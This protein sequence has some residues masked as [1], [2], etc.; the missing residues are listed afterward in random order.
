MEIK[1]KTYQEVEHHFNALSEAGYDVIK[2]QWN[3]D[4]IANLKKKKKVRIQA[5]LDIGRQDIALNGL[6]PIEIIITLSL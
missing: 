6:T 1:D 3:D 2:L 4:I 5:L